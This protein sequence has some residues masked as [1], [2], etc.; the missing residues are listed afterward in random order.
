MK[1]RPRTLHFSCWRRPERLNSR[2]RP[3]PDFGRDLE[4]FSTPRPGFKQQQSL[5]QLGNPTTASDQAHILDN[6]ARATQRLLYQLRGRRRDMAEAQCRHCKIQSTL[7][8]DMY[9]GTCS[10]WTFSRTSSHLGSVARMIARSY[11]G[12]RIFISTT[13][14]QFNTKEDLTAVWNLTAGVIAS[15][16]QGCFLDEGPEPPGKRV[17]DAA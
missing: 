9:S 5:R 1:E 16:P 17:E 10:N 2:S 13:I 3:N 6:G 8:P 11:S 4:W 12:E 14:S 7:I 15:Q